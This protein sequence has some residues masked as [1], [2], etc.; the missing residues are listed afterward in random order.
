[1][2]I[3]GGTGRQTHYALIFAGEHMAVIAKAGW[4][5]EDVQRYCF[6]NS[7]VSTAE[8]K[9]IKLKDGGIE[10]DD[11]TALQS[12]VPAPQDFLVIAAGGRAGSQSAFIPGWGSKT[13]SQSV[14]KAISRP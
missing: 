1:M 6:E 12:L 4:T 11:E 14:T 7:R 2:R 3:S 9:R 13:G 10:P 8:L 5:R